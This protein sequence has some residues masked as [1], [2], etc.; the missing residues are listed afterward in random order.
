MQLRALKARV[1]VKGWK[2]DWALVWSARP[3]SGCWVWEHSIG[4]AQSKG[5]DKRLSF[6]PP[7]H[8]IGQRY[9]QSSVCTDFTRNRR[10]SVVV[11]L[12]PPTDSSIHD[13]IGLSSL[14]FPAS[15]L[16]SVL[17]DSP[18]LQTEMCF[19]EGCLD[20]RAKRDCHVEATKQ[21]Q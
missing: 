19:R 3:T 12:S 2:W 10:N 6:K 1:L 17:L 14:V 15:E 9:S 20:F 16:T 4:T 7:L 5:R 11:M 21:M 8:A 13:A 18:W